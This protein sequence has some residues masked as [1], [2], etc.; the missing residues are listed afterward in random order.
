[1]IDKRVREI[2]EKMNNFLAL[3][4]CLLFLFCG[5]FVMYI[6]FI[7]DA[8]SFAYGKFPVFIGGL[9]FSFYGGILL[10]PRII[11]SIQIPN[12]FLH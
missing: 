9:T 8:S 5:I 3:V 7:E 1:M 11:K 4:F 2:K 12:V 10:L 6:T